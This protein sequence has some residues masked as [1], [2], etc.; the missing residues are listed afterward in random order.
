MVSKSER[1]RTEAIR[2]GGTRVLAEHSTAGRSDKEVA[3]GRPGSWGTEAQ[4]TQ[5][6]EGEAGHHVL[7]EQ[8]TPQTLSCTQVFLKLL[9]IAEQAVREPD[10]VFTSLAH[11]LSPDFLAA[12][13]Y[14]LRQSAAPGFDGVTAKEYAV[15]LEANV[16]QLWERLRTKRYRPSPVQRVWIDKEDGKQRPLGLPVLEDKLVQRAVVMLLQPIYEADFY[17]F[18]YGF[19]P[20]RSPHQAL[21]ALRE[22]C[23]HGGL[24]WIVDVDVSGYFD[25]IDRSLL[26]VFLKRRVNDGSLLRLI[27]Q[28]LA[29]GVLEEGKLSYPETGTPQG[30]VIS[31]LLANIF[32]H[33]VLDEWFVREVQPHMLGKCFLIRFADDFVIGC[34]R[35]DDARRLMRM[36]GER[37]TAHGLTIHPTKSRLVDFRPPPRKV[38]R[39]KSSA[40]GTDGPGPKPSPSEPSEGDGTF[41]FL[42]FTHYWA[43]SRRGSWVIKRRTAAKRMRRGMHAIW[44]R[45]RRCRH[46]PVP[47]QHRALS[48]VLRGHFQYYGI[49]CN[50]PQLK[51]VYQWAR[52]AWRYWL[53]RRGQPRAI[54]WEKYE[55]FLQKYPLPTPRIVHNI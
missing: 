4:G 2:Q 43:R 26:E 54:S 48:A 12:A 10:R 41:D 15:H 1:R 25:S 18:S 13:Y 52:R 40:G 37:S 46:E 23:M 7:P 50:L 11:F 14:R 30:G 51:R 44:Q 6:R 38:G 22:H 32:L 33:Y 29:A 28:W 35:E 36:L 42:G 45:C 3:T 19:R 27:R 8:Q 47:E 17:D 24:G 5:W 31:P 49:R 20:G 55:L 21:S 53:S 9:Q 39:T 34:Q 16:Q